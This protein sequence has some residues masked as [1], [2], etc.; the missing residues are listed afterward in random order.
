MR[1]VRT[2][3][4]FAETARTW[5]SMRACGLPWHDNRAGMH[6]CRISLRKRDRQERLAV[7][8]RNG[9]TPP[10]QDVRTCRERAS[11]GQKKPV[12]TRGEPIATMPTDV[13]LHTDRMMNVP[14][15]QK[16][17]RE[18]DRYKQRCHG[19]H[20]QVL[21]RDEQDPSLRAAPVRVRTVQQNAHV[22]CAQSAW[23]VRCAFP[24][25][26]KRRV[27]CVP[28]IHRT[29]PLSRHREKAAPDELDG[30]PV[31]RRVLHM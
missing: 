27:R 28:A 29:S 5:S 19:S 21:F 25:L 4:I 1:K 16:D 9:Y 22:A 12:E 14:A 30:L 15:D 31:V 3:A 24:G 13:S 18:E 7:R 23:G 26:F 2:S 10:C 20:E 6:H 8:T 17:H 11:V